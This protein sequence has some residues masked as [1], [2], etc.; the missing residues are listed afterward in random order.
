VLVL[1]SSSPYR[2]T[3]LE[4]LNLPFSVASPDI[5][6]GA[7]ENE[8]PRA[9]ALRLAE[10]K[11]RTVAHEYP[12]AYIIGS[13]Q[14]AVLDRKSLGKPGSHAAALAQLCAVRGRSVVFHTAVC[15]VDSASGRCEV[16][17]VPTIVHYRDY[18]DSQAQHY[19]EIER[20]YDCAGSAKIEALGVALVERVESTDPTALIGLPLIALITMLK[21]VG[22]EVL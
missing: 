3:L 1:A 17:E 13:D 7:R 9:T 22:I 10:V 6:E 2:R 12:D 18:T 14:V 15:L 8:T 5:D 21:R 20:P 4:R 11:A 16:E 19:L